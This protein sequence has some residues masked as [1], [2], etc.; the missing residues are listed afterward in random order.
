MP[1]SN[2]ARPRALFC[3]SPVPR[4]VMICTLGQLP[5]PPPPPA[6]SVDGGRGVEPPGEPPRPGRLHDAAA[7]TAS[8]TTASDA[9]T[10]RRATFGTDCIEPSPG[11]QSGTPAG[12]TN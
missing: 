9:T 3:D 6:G 7:P 2:P 1:L 4:G 5:P 11:R 10:R 12:G 8:A